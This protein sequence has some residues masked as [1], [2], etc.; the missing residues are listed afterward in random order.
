MLKYIFIIFFSF[1]FFCL[2]SQSLYFPP[3]IGS[4]WSTTSPESLNWCQSRIDAL[5]SYLDANNTKAFILLKYG[6]IVLE[7]Y[8]GTHTATSPWQWASAGKTITAFMVVIA[9]QENKLSVTDKTS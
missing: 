4:T 9:Q 2:K 6:K 5:Y 1:V 3:T 8:F 7:K